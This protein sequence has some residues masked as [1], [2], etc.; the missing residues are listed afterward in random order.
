MLN[1]EI[2][3]AHEN[4]IIEITE[5]TNFAILNSNYN[6]N[7]TARTIQ[8]ITNWFLAHNNNNYPVI[9]A[10][11]NDYI[12]GWASLSKFR[13]FNGYNQTA[14]VSIYVRDKYYRMGIGKKLLTALESEASQRGFHVLTAV[15]TANNI[16]S[17]ELHKSHKFTVNGVFKEIAYKNNEYLD[18]VFMSK[19]IH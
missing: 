2:R 19:I 17:I 15:I 7:T 10:L 13:N 6:L 4:D 5:I 8:D 3:K 16:P 9:V 12:V 14:E 18:V 11:K 1:I